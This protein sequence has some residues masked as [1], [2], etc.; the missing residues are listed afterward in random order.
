[1]M[2]KSTPS[3]RKPLGTWSARAIAIAL[4]SVLSSGCS[5]MS[6]NTTCALVGAGVGAGAGVI[7]TAAGDNSDA[8]E[9]FAGGAIGALVGAGIG[10]GVCLIAN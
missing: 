3:V 6:Q 9:V 1:M 2:R 4:V 5:A 10:Y 8:G 7:A